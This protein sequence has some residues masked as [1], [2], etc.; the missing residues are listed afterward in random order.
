MID[1]PEEFPNEGEYHGKWG[2]LIQDARNYLPKE[3]LEALDAGYRQLLID[4]F[5]EGVL[6][7]LAGEAPKEENI[8]Y[9]ASGRY[10]GG[11]TDA[12]GLFGSAAVGFDSAPVKAEGEAV[13][14]GE[15]IL[16]QEAIRRKLIEGIGIS[17]QQHTNMAKR[18][19]K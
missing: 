11:F 2:R 10:G 15:Q 7:A 1:C 13:G 12:R 4:R 19:S 6:K 9:K 8:K 14:Y 16:Q 3:D 5:N 18:S 17:H